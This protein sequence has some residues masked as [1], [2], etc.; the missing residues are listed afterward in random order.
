M[1]ELAL[2]FWDRVS[3]AWHSDLTAVLVIV[4]DL[5]GRRGFVERPDVQRNPCNLGVMEHTSPSTQE[6][7][8][9]SQ[10]AAV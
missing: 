3:R 8:H 5:A 9:A 6:V 1:Y 10:Y 7:I 2:A 4:G